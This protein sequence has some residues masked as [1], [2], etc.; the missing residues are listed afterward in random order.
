MFSSYDE[1]QEKPVLLPPKVIEG[2]TAAQIWDTIFS[3]NSSFFKIY[4]E[5][6]GDTKMV[7]PQWDFNSD[8]STGSR[9]YTCDAQVEGS[10]TPFLEA[11]RFAMCRDLQAN[12]NRFVI[13][14][15]AQTPEVICGTTF[16]VEAILEFTEE[17]NNSVRVTTLGGCRKMAGR[18]TFIKRIAEPRACDEMRIAYTNMFNQLAET[19]GKEAAIEP[20]PV[21]TAAATM[22]PP[23]AKP[24]PSPG[25]LPFSVETG[26]LLLGALVMLI[27][28]MTT[29][30]STSPAEDLMSA[31][32]LRYQ[33][34]QPHDELAGILASL[35][36]QTPEQQQQE[37][38]QQLKKRSGKGGKNG[39]QSDDLLQYRVSALE[40]R[41][42]ALEAKNAWLTWGLWF[43]L[44]LSIGL[45]GYTVYST[46]NG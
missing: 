23:A 1:M 28:T 24:K 22:P 30:S 32:S 5:R 27:V 11:A 43:A 2:I 17:G 39:G 46:L 20:V 42:S 4:H 45:V 16:R 35:G 38:N 36:I 29:M 18:F 8:R 37:Q 6:R 19:M 7:I 25:G 3:S 12:T 26:V 14:L 31:S 34:V 10:P 9:L 21:V 33:Q 40:E 44:A 15:S 13:Q 41:V